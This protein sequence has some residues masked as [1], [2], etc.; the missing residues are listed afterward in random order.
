MNKNLRSLSFS[1]FKLFLGVAAVGSFY[2]LNQRLNEAGCRFAVN[3]GINIVKGAGL[4]AVG[5][6]IL[7][8]EYTGYAL[9]IGYLLVVG[10]II[11]SSVQGLND[12][13]NGG[14]EQ[15]FEQNT[16][17]EIKPTTQFFNE[18]EYKEWKKL[19][20]SLDNSV[21]KQREYNGYNN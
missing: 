20:E 16:D 4:V 12:L 21:T 6:D 3:T 5:Q 1:F 18:S 8:H 13:E 15:Y 17:T 7:N 2:I 9:D 19:D 10:F 11:V 14:C